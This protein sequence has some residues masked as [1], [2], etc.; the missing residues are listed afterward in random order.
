V[1]SATGRFGNDPVVGDDLDDHLV[2]IAAFQYLD[3]LHGVHGDALPWAALTG[4]DYRGVAVPLL[5]AAGIWKPRALALPISITTSPKN[6]YGDSIGDDGLLQY[7]Y[8]GSAARA[9]DNVLLRR[10]MAEARPLVYFQGL[11]RG[12]YSAVWP[13]VI[14]GDDPA[15]GTFTVACEDIEQ[16]RPELSPG[17]VD[18]ARRRYVTRLAVARLHQAAFRQRVLRAYRDRCGVCRLRHLPLLDAAHILADVHERGEPVVP[19]GLSLCKI[20]HAAFDANILGV[21]PDFVVEIRDDVLRETDGPMLLHGLQE[22]HGSR[23]VLP[24]A[25][26]D[27]PDPLRLEIRYEEFRQAS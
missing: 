25:E 27:Q 10:A 21:R 18:V 15:T 17:A 19:N 23:L 20:H 22:L 14:V 26:V 11:T 6:P 16:L 13:A 7:R 4:F 8:Q 1:S 3:R 12:F 24:R 2:R 9:Y 5:G